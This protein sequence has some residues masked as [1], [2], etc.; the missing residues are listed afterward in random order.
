MSPREKDRSPPSSN[1]LRKHLGTILYERRT[2][3]G[4]NQ[5]Q[6]AARAGI[7]NSTI[8]KIEQKRLS[9]TLETLSKISEG[10]DLPLPELILAVVPHQRRMQS[11]YTVQSGPWLTMRKQLVSQ[12][13][14]DLEDVDEAAAA[15]DIAAPTLSEWIR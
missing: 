14:E 1:D 4:L 8:S 12:I 2:E 11:Q 6:L 7:S 13:V 5:R 3:L 10:L 15:L 9:P